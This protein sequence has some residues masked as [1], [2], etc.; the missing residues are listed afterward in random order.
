MCR[1]SATGSSQRP[2][3]D[4]RKAPQA[5]HLSKGT[6]AVL[7]QHI[8]LAQGIKGLFPLLALS[9]HAGMRMALLAGMRTSTP[10]V[11]NGCARWDA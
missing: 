1:S 3:D 8:V 10:L 6:C 2:E 7:W 9:N 11:F 5:I 4:L